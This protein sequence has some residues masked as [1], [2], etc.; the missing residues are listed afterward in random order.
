MSTSYRWIVKDVGGNVTNCDSRKDAM[1]KSKGAMAALAKI[2]LDR[3][4]ENVS[5][6]FANLDMSGNMPS[7]FDDESMVPVKFR[8]FQA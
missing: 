3:H 2:V 4:G 8:K 7:R 5:V 1:L 6:A